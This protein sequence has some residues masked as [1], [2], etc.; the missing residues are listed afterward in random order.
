MEDFYKTEKAQREWAA[1]HDR[2]DGP[3]RLL[4]DFVN[5]R[6]AECRDALETCKTDRLYQSQALLAAMREMKQV[7]ESPRPPRDK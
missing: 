6:I 1:F 7:L 5:R 2:P 4:L 3:K